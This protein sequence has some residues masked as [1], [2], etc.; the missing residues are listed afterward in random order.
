[1]ILIQVD[2]PHLCAGVVA[3]GEK[4]VQ[5]APILAWSVGKSPQELA[6]WTLKQG[7]RITVVERGE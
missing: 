1:M 5:A 3:K 2:L 7:G 6:A 4:I